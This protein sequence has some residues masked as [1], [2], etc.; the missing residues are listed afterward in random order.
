MTK[1]KL[2]VTLGLPYCITDP[3]QS[4]DDKEDGDKRLVRNPNEQEH[5]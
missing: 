1:Q 3:P 4:R 2:T 5:H